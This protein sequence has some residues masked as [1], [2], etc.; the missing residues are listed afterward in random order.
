MSQPE[1]CQSVALQARKRLEVR[2]HALVLIS[3]L[4]VAPTSVIVL[5]WA[6]LYV[7]ISLHLGELPFPILALL[8]LA[9]AAAL[10][11]YWVLLLDLCSARRG[12]LPERS[13]MWTVMLWLGIALAFLLFLAGMLAG[14]GALGPADQASVVRHLLLT[15]PPVLLPAAWLLRLR[16]EQARLE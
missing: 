9:A 14:T 11:A 15:G 6:G 1:I 10:T 3:V 8:F 5:L 13:P 16:A 12:P 4:V 7:L 2:K